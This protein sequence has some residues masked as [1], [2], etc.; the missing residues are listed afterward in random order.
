MSVKDRAR[1]KTLVIPPAWTGV[2]IAGSE[3]SSIQAWGFDV[4]G[5]KQYKYHPNAVQRGELQKYYRIRQMA[6]DLPKIRR[7][8]ARDMR[9]RG[10]P[11]EKV[12]AGVVN[13]ISL[14]FFR[15]GSER[16]LK[17]NKTFGITTLNKS[18]VQV[19]EDCLIFNYVGKRSIKHRQVVVAPELARFVKQLVATPGRRL[20]RYDYG[21]RWHVITARDV[22]QYLHEIAGGF[23]YTA[24]DLRT[25]GGT[26]RAATILSEL[27]PPASA[28]EGKR[29]VLNMIRMVASELGNTPAICRTSYVHPVI[30]EQYLKNGTTIDWARLNP[31]KR[32]THSVEEKALIKFLDQYFPE[33]K[34]RRDS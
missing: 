13:L 7:I 25:W 16:Y 20:F 14:G 5:R 22:N 9:R 10:T 26:L 31:G 28:T 17:E 19:E 18:H 23:P 30:I 33:K 2:H 21:G 24:K 3:R 32:F 4:K 29:N 6:R 8:L 12:L 34:K 11:K 1:I 27:G 15:V